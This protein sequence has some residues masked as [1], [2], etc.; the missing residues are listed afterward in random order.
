MRRTAIAQMADADELPMYGKQTECGIAVMS[1]L[2]EVYDGG[3]TRLSA[4][5]IADSRNLSRP[6]VAKILSVL[7]HGGL[8]IGSRGPGGGSALAKDPKTITLYDVFTLFERKDESD[9]C[10]F[11][12]GTCS[13]GDLCPLHEKLVTVQSALDDLLHRTTFD[14]FR[15]A[16]LEREKRRE[17]EERAKRSSKRKTK[18]KT[19]KR[20]NRKR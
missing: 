2:A 8:V 13:I 1:R 19:T 16:H 3:E 14:D 20:S 6:F 15:I 9:R 12:T 7:T 10:P 18:T 5:E 4:I 17:R 11:G